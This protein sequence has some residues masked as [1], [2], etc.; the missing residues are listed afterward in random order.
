VVLL[1]GTLLRVWLAG[2]G[3]PGLSG[4]FLGVLLWLGAWLAA[5]LVASPRTAF[6]VGLAIMAVL[7]IAA[8]PPRTFVQYD[9]RVALHRTDQSL[10]IPARGATAVLLVEPVYT[11]DD[12]AFGLAGDVGSTRLEWTC[13]FRRGMQRLAL[14]VPANVSEV[15]LHLTGN[16]S[17]ESEYLLVY[18]SSAQGGPFLAE[19]AGLDPTVCATRVA[20]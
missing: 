20:L 16:P 6:L 10:S 18:L 14:P 19:R 11:G 12:A 15:R 8:L 17:R 13:P 7:N 1:G 4:L 5:V 9:E 3:V 2:M